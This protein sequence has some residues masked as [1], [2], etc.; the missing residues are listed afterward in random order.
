[1]RRV[2]DHLLADCRNCSTSCRD[3]ANWIIGTAA[4]A[5][6][7]PAPADRATMVLTHGCGV[8]GSALIELWWRDRLLRIADRVV[9]RRQVKPSEIDL[10][11]AAILRVALQESRSRV[12][13]PGTYE[14]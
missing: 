12:F 2:Q 8:P 6:S 7:P 13:H 10:A 11:S 3:V 9:E 4:W 1:M 14:W 5:R